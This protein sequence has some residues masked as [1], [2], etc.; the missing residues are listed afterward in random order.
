[1][2]ASSDTIILM[3][4]DQEILNEPASALCIDDRIG[5][6]WQEKTPDLDF[7]DVLASYTNKFK[8]KEI[9]SF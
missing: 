3:F 5:P 8:N 6:V 9:Q 2:I 1:L 7:S 4:S